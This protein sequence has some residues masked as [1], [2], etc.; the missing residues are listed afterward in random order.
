MTIYTHSNTNHTSNKI[1]HYYH[2]SLEVLVYNVHSTG[3]PVEH[4]TH[5]RWQTHLM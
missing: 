5:L 2:D 1:G 3:E 4:Q